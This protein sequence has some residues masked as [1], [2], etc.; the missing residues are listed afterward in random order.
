MEGT[1][2]KE[3]KVRVDGIP[4][5]QCQVSFPDLDKGAWAPIQAQSGQPA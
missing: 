3:G 5:G 1:L 4:P 2:D